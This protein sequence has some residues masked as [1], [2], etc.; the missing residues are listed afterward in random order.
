MTMSADSFRRDPRYICPVC[1][2]APVP[3]DD[4][5]APLL[6][7]VA[8]GPG[9]AIPG[10]YPILTIDGSRTLPGYW[11]CCLNGHKWLGVLNAGAS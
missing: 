7:I 5:G 4:S 9:V 2:R 6:A 11:Y 1:G 10:H 3:Y 8:G